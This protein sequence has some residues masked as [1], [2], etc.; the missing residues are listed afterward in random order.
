[1]TD[2]GPGLT[3]EAMT[4]LFEPF[5]S[6]K[7]GGTGLGLSLSRQIVQA[8]GGRLDVENA[9]DHGARFRITLPRA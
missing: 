7:P 5:F 4:R 9:A 8:H 1:V 2:T 3:A 6:T